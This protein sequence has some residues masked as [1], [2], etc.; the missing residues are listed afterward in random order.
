MKS[1]IILAA[2]TA[3]AS[4]AS[5]QEQTTQDSSS[6]AQVTS[7]SS[8]MTSSTAQLPSSSS[9]NAGSM[10][11]DTTLNENSNNSTS[12]TSN[13]MASSQTSNTMTSA[14]PSAVEDVFKNLKTTKTPSDSY[15]M[16]AVRAVHARVQSDP[17][18]LVDGVFVS[19]F[20][21]GDLELG[22]LSGMD[23]VNTASVEGCLMYVQAEG[24]NIN[25]R[26]EEERCLRKSGMSVIVFYE[27]LIKQTNETLA[28]FQ[29]T[30][31]LTPEYG[32]M[33]PMD[34]GRCT[35]LSGETDFPA[36]C[37]QFNGEKDQPNLGPFIG[38]GTK[39]DD[40]RAPY[41]DN[42]W[43]SFPGTCPLEAWGDK[44]DSC[45]KDSRKGLCDY[46]QGPNGVDCTFA[47]SVLGW[48]AI[49]DI[50]GITAIENPET[51]STYANFTEWCMADSNNTEFAANAGTGE[52]E[53]GL[54]FW[55]DPLN[56]TAN[57]ARAQIVVATYEST[58]TSGSSQIQSSVIA[59]FRP[60]PTPEQLATLNPPCYQSVEACGSGNGCK[61]VGYSQLC[62]P[63]TADEDCPT[64]G[65]GFVYPTLA[66]AFT[67]LS[68]SETTTTLG[69]SSGTNGGAGG[70]A[71]SSDAVSLTCTIASIGF[72]LAIT[73]FAM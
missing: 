59:S 38:G 46:G 24:I 45:R 3:F 33:L 57:A 31:G 36:G 42:Y 19:S 55:E 67:T 27:V 10:T 52:M 4:I 23:T 65:S 13:N 41:P 50:V 51:G 26:A 69:N 64:G 12:S 47:Y 71:D 18:I 32:P 53:K 49:D 61:R 7:R 28:Q 5:A 8:E 30:W 21:N 6:P 17:P 11:D 40:V 1:R 9:E 39:D 15:H 70:N 29:E 73:V 68:D 25:V 72:G 22:Y 14:T 44:T 16:P 66:K 2:A 60:M 35:P 56:S 48:V 37:L 54:P 43:F 20:G 58:L 62:T 34:S 63:C